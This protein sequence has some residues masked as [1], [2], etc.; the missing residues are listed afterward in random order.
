LVISGPGNAKTETV[1]SLSG[2]GALVSSTIASE[3]AVLSGTPPQQRSKG[4]TGGLLRKLGDD[5]LLVLKDG[6]WLKCNCRSPHHPDLSKACY[7][8]Y[9][10][11]GGSSSGRPCSIAASIT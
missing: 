2:A 8:L 1:Q 9:P 4:A 3:G 10:G 11:A 5:G 6:R 7:Q